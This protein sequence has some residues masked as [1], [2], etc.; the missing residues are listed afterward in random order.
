MDSATKRLL[1]TRKQQKSK[2][3]TFKRTDSHKKKKLDE[4]WRRPRGLQSKLRRRFASKGAVVQVGYG[5]PKAVRGLHPSGFE[6]VLVRNSDDLQPIDPSYQAARIARTVG[7]R[8]RQMIEEIAKSRE[9][10]ILNPLPEE[11]EVEAG[12]V[13]RVEDAET[14]EEA[15]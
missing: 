14:E 2:K 4:N 11:I 1:N 8:K 15:A 13:E 5:S 10:K 12:E 9:I 6:E 3:P 7:V